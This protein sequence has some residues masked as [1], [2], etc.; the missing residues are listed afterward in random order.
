M[1][2]KAMDDLPVFE[3]T[4]GTLCLDLANTVDNRPTDATDLLR[5][6][7]DLLA[8]SEQA[9]VLTAGERD[10]LGAEAARRPPDATAALEGTRALREAIYAIFSS[11]ARGA[12]VP[13]P[14]LGLLNAAIGPSLARLR[15][16]PVPGGFEW[17]WSSADLALD[18]MLAPVVDSAADLLTSPDLARV[19]ECE[20]DSCGWLFIDRS[21]NRSRRWCDMSI[22]GNRAKVRR[23]YRRVRAARVPERQA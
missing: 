22:C 12:A 2:I 1:V 9:G 3:L 21:R 13:P 20:A 16:R 10:A 6:Y 5:T 4:G 17:D 18:G 19:R 11:R 7:A 15:L 8:W 14:A 23:H